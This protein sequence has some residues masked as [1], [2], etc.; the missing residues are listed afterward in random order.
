VREL[1]GEE[2][3]RAQQQR[4]RIMGELRKQNRANDEVN[5]SET[6]KRAL[7]ELL[8]TVKSGPQI[9]L[10]AIDQDKETQLKLG[11][12]IAEMKLK[13]YYR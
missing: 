11:R 8:H 6:E 3:P 12:L 10:P 5:D 7:R 2:W 9:D 1:Q 13:K 4:K